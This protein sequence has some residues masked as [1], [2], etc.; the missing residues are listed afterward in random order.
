LRNGTEQREGYI[1]PPKELEL[2][3]FDLFPPELRAVIRDAPFDVS[4]ADMV[5]NRLVMSEL[6]K[7]GAD[8]PTW[9]K[10]QLE[11]VYR[12]RILPAAL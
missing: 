8:A 7:R 12:E 2:F 3:S 1:A 11:K 9:L 5:A 10:E 4:A 6:E